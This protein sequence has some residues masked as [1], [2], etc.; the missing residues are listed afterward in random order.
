MLIFSARTEPSARAS[1]EAAGCDDY[2]V[3]PVSLDELVTA[4]ERALD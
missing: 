3:K 2:L 1:A 4:I